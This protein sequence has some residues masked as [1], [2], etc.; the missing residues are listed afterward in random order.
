M[1]IKLPTS[2]TRRKLHPFQRLLLDFDYQ[3]VARNHINPLI[4][5]LPKTKFRVAHSQLEKLPI[6]IVS[7]HE[8]FASLQNFL[9][10]TNINH[11]PGPLMIH[12]N[13]PLVGII[14]SK[15]SLGHKF[16]ISGI[17]CPSNAS[18]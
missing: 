7:P 10:E 8:S 2:E 12:S 17:I 6:S 15:T 9:I 14:P 13:G 16:K 3:T 1:P 18:I 5:D 11:L 4:S